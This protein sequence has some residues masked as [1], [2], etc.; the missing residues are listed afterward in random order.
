VTNRAR[1]GC[2]RISSRPGATEDMI[3]EVVPRGR[4]PERHLETMNQYLKSG[5]GHLY[6]D[7]LGPEQNGI[8]SF[9]THDLAPRLAL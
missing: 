3:G 8:R 7:Q 1:F 5:F 4:D 6:I 2:R 9:Y